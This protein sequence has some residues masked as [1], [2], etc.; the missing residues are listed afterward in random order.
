MGKVFSSLW[1]REGTI[2]FVHI[3]EMKCITMSSQHPWACCKLLG[4]KEMPSRASEPLEKAGCCAFWEEQLRQEVKRP[5]WPNH[6]NTD[7]FNQPEAVRFSHLR[8]INPFPDYVWVTFLQH[9]WRKWFFFPLLEE[10]FPDES[11]PTLITLLRTQFYIR[12]GLRL[13]LHCYNWTV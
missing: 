10:V 3:R 1:F 13:S 4:P 12:L 9:R 11:H 2:C 7:T 8:C 5:H 6:D